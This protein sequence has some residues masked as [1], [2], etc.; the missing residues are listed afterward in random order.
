MLSRNRLALNS[1]QNLS[2]VGKNKQDKKAFQ[3]KIIA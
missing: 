3:G 2:K 1:D